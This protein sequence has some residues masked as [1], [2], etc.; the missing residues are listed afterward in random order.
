MKVNSLRVK[1]FR[2]VSI[3]LPI[4]LLAGSAWAQEQSAVQAKAAA[5][6]HYAVVDLGVVGQPPAQPYLIRNNGLISG[7][8]TA[9]DGAMHAVLWFEGAKFDIGTSGLG[10]PNNAAFWR[11]P[12]RA[13]RG[14]GRDFDGQCGRLLRLQRLW[15]F[16]LHR[17]PSFL[18]A[19]RRDEQTRNT[20]R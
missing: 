12:L 20:G 8:A 15:I 1:S 6:A 4:V 14:A 13:D 11:Q 10:G 18:V 9:P 17:M 2:I 3:G 16:F 19:R 7:A 5:P